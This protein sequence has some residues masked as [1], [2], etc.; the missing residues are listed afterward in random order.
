MKFKLYISAMTLSALALSSCNDLEQ[1]PTN[2]FTDEN[3]WSIERAEYMVNMAYNQMYSADR[4]WRD[5]ALSD[6]ICDTRGGNQFDIRKGNTLSTNELF[7]YEWKELYGGI[8]SCHVFLDN[9][10]AMAIDAKEKESLKAQVRFIRAFIYLRLTSFYGDVPFFTHDI[11]YEESQHISR[12]PRAEVINFIHSELNEI[13][14]IL[15]SKDEAVSGRITKAAAAMLN[16]RA[17][18]YDSNWAEVEKICRNIMNGEYGKYSLF[19]SY[20]GLFLVENEY[21]DEVILDRG[22][23]ENAVTWSNDFQDKIVYSI[24][25]RN[26]NELPVQSLIDNYLMINGSTI[27]E[28]DSGYDPNDPYVNRDPR[29]DATVV[30]DGYEWNEKVKNTYFHEFYN[31]ERIVFEGGFYKQKHADAVVTDEINETSNTFNRTGYGCRKY[32]APQA[33]KN[34]NSGLNIIMM[35]YADVLLMYAEAAFEQGKLNEAIWNETIRAIRERAGFTA[36]KA[37]NFP[38]AT[39]DALRKIIRN[40]RRSE[41]AIEGLR[42]FDIMRWKAGEE[43]LNQEVRGA[44]FTTWKDQYRFNPKRDYLWAI[45]AN[46]INLNANLTQNEGWY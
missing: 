9:I 2:E 18:L 46:Q 25:E 20:D 36:D 37:L 40:E 42:Y 32:H 22:Y 8:K 41:L 31:I 16:A 3:F 4:M 7:A 23:L 45:P 30:Y 17:Y 29:M 39:G 13:I 10:D 38:T 43:Y 28:A 26:P 44:A 35:R 11:S 12:T 24:G 21:N 5:E 14:S 34:W 6:N 19:P 27:D 1:L 15:P 33:Q